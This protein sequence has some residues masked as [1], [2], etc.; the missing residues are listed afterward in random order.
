M[1]ALSA[2]DW[3]T[4]CAR[5]ELKIQTLQD[6]FD[7]MRVDRDS[8]QREATRMHE[9][10]AFLESCEVCAKAHENVET[11][12]YC[13]RDELMFRLDAYIIA[14]SLAVSQIMVL[15]AALRRYGQHLPSCLA[16]YPVKCTCGLFEAQGLTSAGVKPDSIAQ[17]DSKL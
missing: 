15:N 1:A 9:K 17:R 13:Q 2:K 14:E 16:Q 6:D 8:H 7:A 3:A 12:G 11:C 10:C 4:E 5:Q